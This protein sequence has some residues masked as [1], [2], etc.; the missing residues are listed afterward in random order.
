MIASSIVQEHSHLEF[1]KADKAEQ[2]SVS[3]STETLSSFNS[4]LHQPHMVW[5]PPRSLAWGALVPCQCCMRDVNYSTRS[6][7]SLKSSVG[8]PYSTVYA[9]YLND[10]GTH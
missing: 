8:L 2:T 6:S 3:R 5:T 4:L 7:V 10:V 9:I 1:Q